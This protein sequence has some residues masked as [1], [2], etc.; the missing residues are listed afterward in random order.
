MPE[1]KSC[2]Y[3]SKYDKE[4]QKASDNFKIALIF[5]CNSR[6]NKNQML[7]QNKVFRKL[8]EMIYYSLRNF[9]ASECD[10]LV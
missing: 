7:E 5:L 4:V 6:N 9:E 1:H 3:S 10:V 2:E 8:F